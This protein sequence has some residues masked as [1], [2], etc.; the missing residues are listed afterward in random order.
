M[1]VDTHDRTALEDRTIETFVGKVLG[2]VRIH[3]R[4]RIVQEDMLSERIDR[5][6]KCD[7][8]FL[9]TAE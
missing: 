4:K 5:T 1:G 2:R 8:S 9:A 3:S 6:G 7:A